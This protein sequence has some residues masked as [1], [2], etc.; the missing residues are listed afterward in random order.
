MISWLFLLGVRNQASTLFVLVLIT[1]AAASGIG[2]LQVDTSF[3]SLI[4]ANDPARA[5]YQRIANEFGSDNRTLIYVRDDALWTPEKLASLEALQ[6]GLRQVPHVERVDGLFNLRTVEGRRGRVDAQLLVDGVPETREGALLARDRALANPLYRYNFFSPDGRVTAL[7]VSLEDIEEIP[8]ASARVHDGIE[9]LLDR[10]RGDFER[11]FQVGPPRI[12]VELTRSLFSDMLLLG[13][14]AALVLIGAILLFMRSPMAAILPLVTSSL[15]VVWTLGMLGWAGVPLNILS[16]MIPALIIVIGS[17]EDTHII[18]AYFR[19]LAEGAED[20]RLDAVRYMAR[21]MGLPLILTV[22]TT[23]L[24]FAANLFSN[25]GM[26]QDFA[27]ASTFAMVANGVITLL[28]VPMLLVKFGSLRPPESFEEERRH[29]LPRRIV[30]LFR[31]S[32]DRFPTNTLAVTAALCV[33]FIWQASNLYVTNDPLSYFP[34]D[35]PLIQDT[36]RVADDLAGVKFFYIALEGDHDRAF[37]EPANVTRLAEIQRFIQRQGAF[38]A[39][40]SIADHLAFVHREFGGQFAELALPET[41]QLVAQYL[42]FFHRGD[43]EQYVSHDYRRANI[44]VR[45]NINDSYTLNAHIRELED[46]IDHIAAPDLRVV[47]T[48]ENLLVNRAAES[49]MLGQVQ[50]LGLLLG[51]IFLVMSAMFTSFK[52]GAIALIPAV[53]PI[54]LMFGIMGLLRIPLNPGTAMVA[55]IAVGIAIDGTIHLLARYNELCRRTSDYVG[56]VHQAV[57]EE[58]TPLIV[59]SLALALG[60]G[61]L[62]FSNFTVVAQFGA[63]AAATMLFSILANLLITPIVMARVRLVGLYQIL[64]ISVNKEVLQQSP[65]FAGMSEY[66]RRKAVLISETNDFA[67]SECLVEQG[68]MGRSMYLILD[69]HADVVRRGEDGEKVL[70]TLGPGD[71]FGEIGYIRAVER[72]ADVRATGPVSALRFDYERMQKDL[73]FFPNIVAQLNFNISTI[74]GERLADMVGTSA[75]KS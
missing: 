52:G 29:G 26:I 9:R 34:A 59:S 70:A 68:T 62:L 46:V 67:S 13:P 54:A 2:R 58:A 21:H 41:R 45:H 75:T 16:A 47:I 28:L 14:L 25:I 56:A 43:L 44:V 35:R 22:M 15:A 31:V 38:D 17:T 71:V 64:A 63:L 57:E 5:V 53:I 3:D 61:V 30:R 11:V 50:A 74:L 6:R 27:I 36:R 19:G 65:L 37:Q 23:A 69:G 12:S 48:G 33:F 10:H 73:K 42:L 55:V 60:F 18:A 51:L 40:L 24:G 66:Q 8:D 49:L 4:P 20:V 39:S 1:L 7:I 32:Q 72:T